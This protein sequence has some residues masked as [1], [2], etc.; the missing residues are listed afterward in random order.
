[1]ATTT[2]ALLMSLGTVNMW[3]FSP[4][5][6][7]QNALPRAKTQKAATQP[8]VDAA[9]ASDDTSDNAVNILVVSPPTRRDPQTQHLRVRKVD[10]DARA[11]HAAAADRAG[12][13]IAAST[14]RQSVSRSVWQCARSGMWM[15]SRSGPLSAIPG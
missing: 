13:G 8:A 7:L 2:N 4:A 15:I 3:G 9:F 5:L 14:T 12:L 10:R 6:D 11:A 1:M